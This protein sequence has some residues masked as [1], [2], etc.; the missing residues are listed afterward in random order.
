VSLVRPNP[1]PVFTKGKALFVVGSHDL[2]QLRARDGEVVLLAGLAER[3]D[4][5]PA[6]RV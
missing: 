6:G 2:I 3:L 1:A 4:I 5:D